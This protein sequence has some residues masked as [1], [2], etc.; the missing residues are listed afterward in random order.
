MLTVKN[1][2]SVYTLENMVRK[3]GKKLLSFRNHSGLFHAKTLLS[4]AKKKTKWRQ[5]YP[6]KETQ[7]M[8]SD[9]EES[10]GQEYA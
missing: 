6:S 9:S 8:S 10:G 5:G 2:S 1:M 3:V 7:D 4:G